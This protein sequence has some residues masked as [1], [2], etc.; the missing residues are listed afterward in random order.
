MRNAFLSK[1]FERDL[2]RNG[3][4]REEVVASLSVSDIIDLS[5]ELADVTLA[6]RLEPD[7]SGFTHTASLSLSGAPFPCSTQRCRISRVNQVAHF[8]ALYSDRVYVSS[9]LSFYSEHPPGPEVS[10][11]R[12]RSRMLDDL[13]V[14]AEL[15]PLMAS[16]HIVPVTPPT[17][18]CPSC[19]A[20][21]IELDDDTEELLATVRDELYDRYLHETEIQARLEKD[22]VTLRVT[23]P[24][25]LIEHG[26]ILRRY[27]N[28]ESLNDSELMRELQ[29]G[30]VISL[31]P[32][33]RE[34]VGTDALHVDEIMWNVV[35]EL[36]VAHSLG[37]KYLT[38]HGLQIHLL[39]R[40]TRR[41]H[42]AATNSLLREH[43]T[44]LVPYAHDLALDQLLKLRADEGDAFVL[45]RQALNKAVS[46]AT[47]GEGPVDSAA[48]KMIFS[49][50]L[51]PE[52][53]R[54]GERVRRAR[55][56]ILRSTAREAVVWVGALSFGVLAGLLP[57]N[58]AGAA[59]TLGLGKTAAD[60][61][62]QALSSADADQAIRGE[63]LYFLWRLRELSKGA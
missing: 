53:A 4:P 32:A 2:L 11:D 55:E 48:L 7:R 6:D 42:I 28:V 5:D 43:L 19:L 41:D 29:S 12:V 36:S 35:F 22:H 39:D 21:R 34:R 16:G 44:A 50:V 58:L 25:D 56:T 49:D 54:L 3:K 45:F 38:D 13:N 9:L 59:A 33:Q 20:R 27:R 57:A 18:T 26:V 14:I 46:E 61:S 1:L 51:E 62:K 23:G 15:A 52:V 17:R 40:V 24:T 30:N 31:S 37:T 8:A 63:N 47:S 60:L 10:P